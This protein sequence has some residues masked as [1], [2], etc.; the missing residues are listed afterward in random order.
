MTPRDVPGRRR[1]GNPYPLPPLPEPPFPFPLFPLFPLFPGPEL[2]LVGA[3]PTVVEVVVEVDEGV[4]EE[5]VFPQSLRATV[6][7]TLP[8]LSVPDLSW[9]MA[10][11]QAPWLSAAWS[12][13]P[14]PSVPPARVVGVP[15]PPPTM[16]VGVVDEVVGRVDEVVVVEPGVSS[17]ASAATALEEGSGRTNG[18][19]ALTTDA[20]AC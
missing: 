5:V 20:T 11:T 6:A 18:V 4:D 1:P 3:T 13:A 15:V 7:T 14:S 17:P 16:V 10:D 8:W 9:A 19:V 2:P 12:S